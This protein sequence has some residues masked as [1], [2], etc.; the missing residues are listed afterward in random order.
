MKT[1]D[2]QND[3]VLVNRDFWNGYAPE[4]VAAGER[5]WAT[6]KPT[7]GIWR[8]PEADLKLLPED[9]T[10]QTSIELGCGT[11]YV[12]CWLERLG[13]AAT[14]IDASKEQLTTAR[15]LAGEHGSSIN[16]IEG[17]AED[18]GLP[19]ESFDFAISEYGAA[20]WCDPDVWI[21]E[22][23]RLLKP[24]GRLVFLGNH[25]LTIA[26]SPWNGEPVSFGL[27]RPLKGLTH[28]DWTEV[29]FDPGGIEFNRTIG[30]WFKLFHRVGF[31]VEDYHEIFAPDDASG[32]HFS[33]PADWAQKY[34]NEQVW[35]LRKR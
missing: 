8:I 11:G 18:T 6:S 7:W 30:D 17:N 14:G 23:Y 9:M 33:C 27:H 4:W 21:P 24:G 12:S 2:Q 28:A 34:P 5:A 22:A 1:P 29:E 10:G 3:H 20:I 16:F 25:P 31:E 15:R 35:K 32:E 13:A 19:D 26:A